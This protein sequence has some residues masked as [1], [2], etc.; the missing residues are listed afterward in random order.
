MKCGGSNLLMF[1]F[2]SQFIFLHCFDVFHNCATVRTI[3]L[4][5]FTAQQL[6]F[7]FISSLT[8]KLCIKFCI[9]HPPYPNR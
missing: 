2:Y 3:P 5:L 4:F 9:K 7:V 1:A 8:H 6:V